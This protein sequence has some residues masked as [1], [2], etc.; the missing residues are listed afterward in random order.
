MPRDFP[1]NEQAAIEQFIQTRG[2]KRCRPAKASG[3]FQYPDR[4]VEKVLERMEG[5]IRRWFVL[6][7]APG[8]DRRVHDRLRKSAIDV[9]MPECRIRRRVTRR[10]PMTLGAPEPVFPGYLLVRVDLDHDRWWL[11]EA[12]EGAERFLR[13]LGG[14]IPA[15]V[16]DDLVDGLKREI[17]LSG[18]VLVIDKG[19]ARWRR[20]ASDGRVKTGDQVRL[21]DGAFAGS[22]G[23]CQEADPDRR[24]KILLD[25]FGRR[26]AVI[27]SEALVEP[28]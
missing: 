24:I 1:L 27:V 26:T 16:P 12:V 22:V 5:I 6:S 19:R 10:S 8:M 25:I 15:A 28:A 2:V 17:D 14:I 3:T 4:L 20:G 13:H 21:L 9:W 18:G 23:I 11:L 7:V